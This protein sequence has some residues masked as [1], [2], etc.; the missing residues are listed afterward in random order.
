MLPMLAD[1]VGDFNQPITFFG[2]FWYIGSGKKR[3]AVLR[4]VAERLE[5]TGVHEC[6]NVMRLTV[7]YPARLLR[8]Q[9]GRQLIQ[10]CQETLLVV[11]HAM[12]VRASA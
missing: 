11:F 6:R 2:Q 5:Q 9:A 4:G 8:R 10:E 7:Y 12:A 3:D 1:G